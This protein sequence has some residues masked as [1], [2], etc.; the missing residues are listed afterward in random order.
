VTKF[1][2]KSVNRYWRYRGNKKLPRES[3]THGR[4]TRKHVASAGIYWR[5]RLKNA[6]CA[7]SCTRVLEK[8]KIPESQNLVPIRFMHTLIYVSVSSLVKT[9]D[10]KVTKMM[11]G[12]LDEATATIPPKILQGY[13]QTMTKHVQIDPVCKEILS[14]TSPSIITTKASH[15]K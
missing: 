9:G 14:K 11:C 7:V 3:W 15:Q 4:T 12:I 1:W 13:P 8:Q 10:V 6:S 5:R 2:Q